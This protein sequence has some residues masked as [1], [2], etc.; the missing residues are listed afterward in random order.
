MCMDMDSM[1]VCKGTE[2]IITFRRRILVNHI[3]DYQILP[4]IEKAYLEHASREF[5]YV[6]KNVD[7]LMADSNIIWGKNGFAD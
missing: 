6:D 5:I 3:C 7:P 4:D 1:T 2:K